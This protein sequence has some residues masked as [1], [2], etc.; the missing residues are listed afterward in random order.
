MELDRAISLYTGRMP[1]L[2]ELPDSAAL[3]F[4]M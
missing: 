3:E 2:T 4:R 1:A